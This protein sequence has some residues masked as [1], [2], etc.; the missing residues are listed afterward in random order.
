MSTSL[1]KYFGKSI[2]R[3]VMASFVLVL[4]LPIAFF[5]YSLLQKPWMQ[6]E[7]KMLEKH[8]LISAALV[9]PFTIFFSS[10]QEALH[11]LGQELLSIDNKKTSSLLF[12]KEKTYLREQQVQNILDKHLKSFG[13]FI[14]LYYTRSSESDLD[15]ISSVNA[16][17]KQLEQLD[18]LNL[19]LNKMPTIEKNAFGKDFLSPVVKSSISGKPVILIKH[20]I[21]DSNQNTKGTIYAEV[22]LDHIRAICSGI[23]FGVKGHC[24][25]VDSL[26]HAVAHPNKN[27]VQEIRDLSKISI[28]QQMLAGETGTTIFYSPFLKADMV[29]GFSPIPALGWGVMIPQPKSELTGVLSDAR[30]STFIWLVAGVLLALLVSVVLARKVTDPI[31]LLISLTHKSDKDFESVNLGKSPTHIP[32]E[33]QQLWTSFSNLLT[34]LQSSNKE[35][36][37]LNLSLQG[38][39]QKATADLQE[40]NKSLYITS[41]QDYLT[42]ISNRRHFTEFLAEILK[43]KVGENIGIIMIDVDKFKSL[44]DQ[45]GHETGDLALKHLADTLKRSTRPCDLVARLGGD[46]F[47]I[48]IQNPTDSALLEIGENIREKMELNPLELAG[49]NLPFTLSVGT[50]NRSNNGRLSIEE[51]L[52][53][54]DKAMYESKTAGRNRVSTFQHDI[55][56]EK[57][58]IRDR[59]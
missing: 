51:L 59:A 47:I 34:G 39:I 38:D 45:Y 55:I 40:M 32:S 2:K 52:R 23:Q 19:P 22:S 37:R 27:W 1:T 28:V 42:S 41:S 8:H 31:N 53:F 6:V 13:N 12:A 16:D 14:A 56:G 11:T 29:A 43:N 33:I 30:S 10:R 35:V 50:V 17:H 44:N 15:S 36:K 57:R 20:S 4:M 54:A 24:A 7:D 3:M 5:V 26:G 48:Y 58:A 49:E 18:Y 46:E 25:V 9:E 21:L